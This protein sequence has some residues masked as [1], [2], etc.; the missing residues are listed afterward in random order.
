MILYWVVATLLLVQFTESDVESKIKDHEIDAIALEIS[1]AKKGV[2]M[3]KALEMENFAKNI[4]P[5]DTKR[6]LQRWQK[7]VTH[8]GI[9]AR[10]LLMI[11]LIRID[12]KDLYD[13]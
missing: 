10:Q 2:E 3:M 4:A 11:Q 7:E 8:M 13:K 9:P 6:L 5:G 1:K 12:L